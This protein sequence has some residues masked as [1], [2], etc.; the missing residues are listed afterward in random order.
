MGILVAVFLGLLPAG[1]AL[2]VVYVDRDAPGP[3]HDGTSWDTAFLTIQEGV[4]A[5][6]P[7]GEV[8]VAD[9][10]YVENVGV[11]R[12]VQLYGGFLGAEPG[13]YETDCSQRDFANNPT[14]IDGNRAGSCVFMAANARVDGFTITRGGPIGSMVDGGGIRCRELEA[15]GGVIAN[16]TITD[17]EAN[18]G[19]GIYCSRSS[20]TIAH[21]T[22]SANR[23]RRSGGGIHCW[24]SAPTLSD[25]TIAGNHAFSSGGGIYCDSESPSITGNTIRD[26][27]A[28]GGGGGIHCENCAPTVSGNLIAE[29]TSYSAG[30]GVCMLRS[31]ARVV[32]NTIRA[33]RSGWDGGGVA[34]RYYSD[35]AIQDNFIEA[36]WANGCGGGLASTD[37][38]CPS[39]E[40]NSIL[41]NL[42]GG[43]GGGVYGILADPLAYNEITGNCC[44]GA[45][46]GVRLYGSLEIRANSICGNFAAADGGGLYVDRCDSY[47]H[48]NAI[49][50]NAAR[51]SGAGL[52]LYRSS[53]LVEM[54]SLS[55]NATD[56]SGGGIACFYYSDPTIVDNVVTDNSAGLGGGLCVAGYS[57]PIVVRN[58][59]VG[60]CASS[61]GGGIGVSETSPVILGNLITDNWSDMYGGGAYIDYL[62]APEFAG[63][64]VVG[65]RSYY[66]AGI[67][68][69]EASPIVTN[70]TVVSNTDAHDGGGI[71]CEDEGSPRV[72]NNIIA[73]NTAKSGGGVCCDSAEPTLNN[74]DLWQNSPDDYVGC[75]P[76]TGDIRG[77]PLFADCGGR[78]FHLTAGSPCI[79]AGSDDA[80]GIPVE[81]LDGEPRTMDGDDDGDAVIDIGADEFL[82][83]D[84]ALAPDS[85]FVPGWVWFSIPLHPAAS[86]EASDVLGF[87]CRNRLFAWDDAKKT[88]VVYPDDFVDL[89][90]G[91]SYVARLA[92]GEQYSPAY[93]GTHPERPW[94]LRLSAAGWYWVGLPHL[95]DMHGLTLQ[96]VKGGAIRTPAEDRAASDPWVNWN[97]IY[98]DPAGQS[99]HIMDPFGAGDDEWLHPWW[100]YRVWLNTENVTIVFP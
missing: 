62:S 31:L 50:G 6:N 21:N 77:D 85:W 73:W 5:A 99:A 69:R 66:G 59:I 40:G 28:D 88:V 76:G 71:Y 100:G 89:I 95:L 19:G 91:P 30:G 37:S 70:N 4:E 36:N 18:E 17:N 11:R 55:G 10:R 98:W 52:C 42:A 41:G 47:I 25:N 97:W 67:A 2:A 24:Q 86:A 3:A 33:N 32:G 94:G 27:H 1:G 81:D 13:G 7:N 29:N 65:N 14:V 68:V 20:P 90:V 83:V 51:E 63:N 22:I 48:D 72:E 75:S 44:G 84:W 96:V 23:A 38:S 92:A 60:N 8:W 74:N 39:V 80:W 35:A 64:V 49:V 12:G 54:N 56:G 79:D 46:G 15:E 61:A 58:A 26:N 53:A 43:D 34:C 45:G 57:Y 93:E 82:L 78:D 87:D 16:N 9:G